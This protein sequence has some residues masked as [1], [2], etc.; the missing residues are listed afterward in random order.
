MEALFP[1]LAGDA[2]FPRFTSVDAPSLLLL[3]IPHAHAHFNHRG[4]RLGIQIVFTSEARRGGV[5]AR[6]YLSL[7]LRPKAGGSV[8]S[9]GDQ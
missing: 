3:D 7:V 4:L 2:T 6:V 9:G 1:F 8:G 5:E